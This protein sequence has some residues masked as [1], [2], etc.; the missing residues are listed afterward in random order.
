MT[1]KENLS[2]AC[3]CSLTISTSCLNKYWKHC[4]S[5]ALEPYVF[6]DKYSIIRIRH[7]TNPET[8]TRD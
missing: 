3:M 2:L 7:V 1:G 8:R 5:A 4:E 6:K